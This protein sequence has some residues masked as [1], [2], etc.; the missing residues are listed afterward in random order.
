MS[1]PQVFF[2]IQAKIWYT[3]WIEYSYDTPRT[4][5]KHPMKLQEQESRERQDKA[6]SSILGE[7]FSVR[8]H[9]KGGKLQRFIPSK[10]SLPHSP[11]QIALAL[12]VL[13]L[14]I[15][16]TIYI[17]TIVA[18]S[19]AFREIAGV[20]NPFSQV[21][22]VGATQDRIRETQAQYEETFARISLENEKLQELSSTQA[23]SSAPELVAAE[24]IRKNRPAWQ[25]VMRDIDA[26]IKRTVQSNDIL[27]RIVL[28][29]ITF[30]IDPVQGT[31]AKT[32]IYGNGDQS[33]LDMAATFLKSLEESDS[34]K[35]V[36]SS[37]PAVTQESGS[38]ATLSYIP[39]DITFTP[40]LAQEITSKDKDKSLQSVQENIQ[41]FFQK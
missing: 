27:Q 14:L 34:M 20:G 6:H 35:E 9:K 24:S 25:A 12:G 4:A 2:A 11:W 30:S 36:E 41:S 16:S 17:G 29:T 23:I 32:K 10:E 5:Y 15:T 33:S 31:L 1:I 40:Q 19:P 18:Y 39:L 8:E 26:S 21:Q 3:I 37:N 22:E 38:G 7:N 28:G 13:W